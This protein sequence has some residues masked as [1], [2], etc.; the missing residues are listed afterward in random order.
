MPVSGII[1]LAREA[2]RRTAA[3]GVG[4]GRLVEGWLQRRQTGTNNMQA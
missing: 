4:E 3:T 2:G 1:K